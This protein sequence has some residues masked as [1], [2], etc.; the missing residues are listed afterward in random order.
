[1]L[2]GVVGAGACGEQRG[3]PMVLVHEG[4]EERP[5]HIQEGTTTDCEGAEADQE[6]DTEQDAQGE[7]QDGQEDE[8]KDDNG[9]EGQHNVARIDRSIFLVI[10]PLLGR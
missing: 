10:I 5:G 2:R 3:S 8:D 1:V 6:A 9:Q 4:L 7:R